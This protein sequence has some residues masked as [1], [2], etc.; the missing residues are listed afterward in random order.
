MSLAQTEI[1]YAGFAVFVRMVRVGATDT[2]QRSCVYVA[3]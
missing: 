1:N 3:N 2:E